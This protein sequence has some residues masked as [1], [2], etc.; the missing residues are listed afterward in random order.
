MSHAPAVRQAATLVL[1]HDGSSGLETLLL[2]RSAAV[3]FAPGAWVFP[4]GRVEAADAE[5]AGGDAER[6]ARLAAVRETQEESAL[7]VD[8]ATLVHFAHWTTPPGAPRRYATWFFLAAVPAAATAVQVDAGEIVAY[9]WLAPAA[10]LQAHHC[11]ELPM[12][13]PTFVTLQQLSQV[14]SVAEA[15][16]AFTA[17]A[18]EAYVPKA[19]L[20]ESEVCFLYEGDSGYASGRVDAPEPHHRFWMGRQSRYVKS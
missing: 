7:A 15:L 9:R 2:Q 16:D 10:A 13:P 12:M 5:A 14:R 4:G 8:P 19:V 3:D 11:G 6:A 17:R 20:C 1:L 18:P